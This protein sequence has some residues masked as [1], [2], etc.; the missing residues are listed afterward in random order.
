MLGWLIALLLGG[1]CWLGLT[2][3]ARRR[4]G[5]GK[6]RHQRRLSKERLASWLNPQQQSQAQSRSQVSAIV[7]DIY[8]LSR[9]EC[10][11]VVLCAGG[12]V[13]F[14]GYVFY[15]SALVSLALG[16]L[17]LLFPRVWRG[18]MIR[19]R[20]ATLLLQFR[21][22]LYCLS[23][24][25][26]AGKSIENA[27]RDAL[28]DL[29]LLYLDP[30][31]LI[32]REFGHIVQRLDNGE[33][34]EHAVGD[35][36][37]RASKEDIAQFADVLQTCKRT[38]GNLVE[39]MRRT[40][41]ILSEKLEIQSDIAVMVAQKKFESRVLTV[42]PVF[43]VAVLGLTSAEYMAPMYEGVGRILMTVSLAALGLC[44]WFTQKLMRIA[45]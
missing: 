37:R 14:L 18:M 3:S 11:I 27:F 8:V 31:S 9:K 5:N 42:A 40:S 38:G 25:L 26:T 44:F 16:L 12:A 21:Q 19:R 2:L 20:K 34:V 6:T 30:E 1:G 4:K 28:H 24:S 10:L 7:Y 13:A 36:A 45:V 23:S 43:I 39:V 29:R 15:K 35:F 41:A 17:G 22:G 33:A 32:V